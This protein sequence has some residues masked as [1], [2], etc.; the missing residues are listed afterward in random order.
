MEMV[1]L[2]DLLPEILTYAPNCA[3]PI[4]MRFLREAARDLCTTGKMWRETDEIVLSTPEAVGVC[5]IPDASIIAIDR[6]ELAGYQL[7]PKTV[8]WL[9]VNV[10]DWSVR[11]TDGDP[12]RFI[13]Q[14]T[15]NTVTVV[16]RATGRL[17]VRLVLQPSRNAMMIPGWMAEQYGTEL[18]KGAAGRILVLPDPA[19]SNVQLGAPLVGEFNSLLRNLKLAAARGQQGAPLRTRPHFF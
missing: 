8:G 13:T 17:K 1:P 18:G 7:D 15:P 3:D 9:D 5:T 4:A 16:P 2:D 10:P 19:V 11:T 14:M 12:A 6:A